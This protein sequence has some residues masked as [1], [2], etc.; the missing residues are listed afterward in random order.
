MPPRRSPQIETAASRGPYR[1]HAPIDSACESLEAEALPFG[2]GGW[3]WDLLDDMRYR[4]SRYLELHYPELTFDIVTGKKPKGH[5][6]VVDIGR[7]RHRTA[8]WRTK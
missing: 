8:D 5:A 1:Y 6:Y 7:G 3:Q 4:D 2:C